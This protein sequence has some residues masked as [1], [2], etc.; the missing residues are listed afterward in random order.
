MKKVILIN[1][2][3]IGEAPPELQ[4]TLVSNYVNNLIAQSAFPMAIC[5]Y[6]SGVY[7]CCTGSVV[8]DQLKTLAGAGTRIVVCKTCLTYFNQLDQLQVGEI[9]S[10]QDIVSL[11]FAAD[12]VMTL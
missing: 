4:Q 9:G 11:Q 3:G 1:T 5:F 8:I 6:A 7:L 10:M 2:N 12:D